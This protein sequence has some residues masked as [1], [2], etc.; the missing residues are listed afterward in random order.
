[1]RPMRVHCFFGL[2]EILKTHHSHWRRCASD[3]L[4][5]AVLTALTNLTGPITTPDIP[6]PRGRYHRSY[7]CN[8]LLSHSYFGRVEGKHLGA[9][10][11]P[12]ILTPSTAQPKAWAESKYNVE[13]H[14]HSQFNE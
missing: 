4:P 13:H 5:F 2:P 3:I 1:M 11:T 12:P 6:Q 7:R 14:G 8:R 9:A 10:Q